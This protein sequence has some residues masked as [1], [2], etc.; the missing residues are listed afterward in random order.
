[1]SFFTKLFS[2]S[3][4]SIDG[5][6]ARQIISEGG[7]LVD[8]R[9]ASEWNAGHAPTAMHIPLD[10]LDRKMSQLPTGVPIVTVCKSGARSA[11]AA[12][13]L[14]AHGFEVSSVRG[15]MRS[16]QNAGGRVIAKSGR[17]GTV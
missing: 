9:T 3:F 6:K 8:V 15:G 1:M 11:A 5:T 12:R 2:K 4:G 17:E 14:A 16:W 13:S 7:V 10:Q